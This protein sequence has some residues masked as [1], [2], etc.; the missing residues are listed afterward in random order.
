[1]ATI[2]ADGAINKLERWVISALVM[3]LVESLVGA[4]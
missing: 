1:M 2:N 3:G 4:L